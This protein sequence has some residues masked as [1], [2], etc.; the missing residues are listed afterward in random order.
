MRGILI[1]LLS[2]TMALTFLTGCVPDGPRAFTGFSGTGSSSGGA[3]S[4]GS[5]GPAFIL[6]T[7]GA[8]GS[9][10]DGGYITPTTPP[11]SGDHGYI[12]PTN[13]L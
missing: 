8:G 4:G 9:G 1:R 13:F 12:A 7:S 10:N 3:P 6:P 2:P 11:S 5:S